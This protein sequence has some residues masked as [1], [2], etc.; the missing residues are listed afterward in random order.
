MADDLP[1]LVIVDILAEIEH[2]SGLL[3][4]CEEIAGDL[5]ELAVLVFALLDDTRLHA[6]DHLGLVQH[7]DYDHFGTVRLDTGQH[8]KAP[9]LQTP[10]RM[11]ARR[12]Q[13]V[14]VEWKVALPDV[15]RH[16]RRRGDHERYRR[17]KRS[18]LHQNR[19]TA[20]S[21][22]FRSPCSA[23]SNH[24]SSARTPKRSVMSY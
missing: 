10:V 12:G 22:Y 21:E 11:I 18:R 7:R 8:D 1:V 17:D 6:V 9:G 16:S 15:I 20:P 13:R 14:A 5:G 23:L 4:H 24:S 2:V 19:T 3:G